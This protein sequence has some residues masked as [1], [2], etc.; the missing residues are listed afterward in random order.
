MGGY[1]S[2]KCIPHFRGGHNEP[3]E[4]NKS[5][6]AEAES[7]SKPAKYNI[8]KYQ[9]HNNN[10]S[11]LTVVIV[12]EGRVHW[13]IGDLVIGCVISVEGVEDFH[14]SV[15][16]SLLLNTGRGHLR[17]WSSHNLYSQASKQPIF[18]S[19]YFQLMAM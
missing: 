17:W 2:S 3:I 6:R 14:H 10:S 16:I 4:R 5:D 19:I 12:Q 13:W 1:R 15:I 7:Q 8:E 9:I 11:I 18:L